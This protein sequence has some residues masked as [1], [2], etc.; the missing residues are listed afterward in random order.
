MDQFKKFREYELSQGVTVRQLQMKLLDIFLYF[1]K[2]CEDNN[3]TYWC[4]GGTMLGAVRHKGF[5]PWDDDLDV[6]MPRKDYEILYAK[7]KEIADTNHY[8]LVRSDDKHNYHHTAMN[9]VD[10]QSTYVNRHNE[11][12]DIY[13]GCYIDIIPFEGCPNSKIGRGLQIYHSIMYSVFNCQRLPDNQGKLLRYPVMMLLGL[14]RSP[15]LRY[16]IWKYHQ[17]KMTK[18]DFYTSKYAKETI[19]SFK[20]LFRHYER[21]VFDTTDAEFEGI[22]V[23]I[24]AGYD[25]YMKQIYG[26]YMA[27]PKN[28]NMD[29]SNRYG[30]VKYVN[31]N[32]PY[33]KFRGKYY[34]ETEE[35]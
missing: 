27:M 17:D 15:K 31:L 24:P 19:S 6:F 23:K 30:V 35:K 32:E 21:E 13:H 34:L 22:T 16:K 12:E 14:I 25:Y 20:G 33:T 5:I 26:D 4:G 3:L 8:V 10:I 28:L 18:Y 2:I 1:K 9:L 29:M 11:N 7:W